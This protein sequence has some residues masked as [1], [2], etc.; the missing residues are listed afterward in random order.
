MTAD[1]PDDCPPDRI[2]ALFEAATRAGPWDPELAR[3]V[4]LASE[5]L[6]ADDRAIIGR[7]LEQAVFLSQRHAADAER[8]AGVEVPRDSPR[9]T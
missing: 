3:S 9:E 5:E 6:A 7:F 4:Q 2:R 1:P 8:A